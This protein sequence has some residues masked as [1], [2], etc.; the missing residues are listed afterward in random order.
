MTS[1]RAKTALPY[2]SLQRTNDT[3]RKT[4]TGRTGGKGLDLS[5]TLC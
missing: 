2:S 3:F 4:F 5:D 1:A